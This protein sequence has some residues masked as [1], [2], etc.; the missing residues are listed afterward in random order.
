MSLPYSAIVPITGVVESPTFTV[1]KKHMLLAVTS[2]LM[3]TST[4]YLEFSGASAIADFG[5]YFGKSMA[6]YAQLQK[7]FGFISKNGNAPEKAV[8]ARW[9]NTDTAAFIKGK[10][11]SANV[12]TLNA[13]EDGALA[14]TMNGVTTAVTGIDFSGASAYSDI[15]SILQLAFGEKGIGVSVVYNS[16]TGGFIV[17]SSVTGKDSTTGGISDIDSS[18]SSEY[19]DIAGLLGLADAELSQGVNAESFAE[20]CDRIYHANTSGY[21]ITTLEKLTDSDIIPAVAW[22]QATLNGQSYNTMVRLVFNMNDKTEAKA[23]SSTLSADGYTGYV[24]CYDPNNEFINILDCAICASIDYQVDGGSINFNFQP[25]MGYTAI[26]TLGTVVDYQQG[27]TNASLVED[28][29]SNYIS[30]VYSVGFGSQEEIYYGYGLMAGDFGTESVQ[31]DESALE[32][33]IQISVLNGLSALNKVPLR[34][35]DA[36]DLVSSL[37][38]SPISQFVK[39]GVIAQG[40]V[41]T[42]TE[43]ASVAQMTGNANAAD[44][45]EMSG[46]YYKIYDLTEEDIA[47]K[48]VR[49]LLCYLAAGCLNQL[50]IVNKVYGA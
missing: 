13:I 5:S 12:S 2:P 6:E 18:E 8:V 1:E 14:I 22:L 19:T 41:L 42:A 48:R 38:A 44:S 47:A 15:A 37:L 10:K 26:T 28:L 24:I 17:T 23:L 7:Y 46:Y 43:K 9:Y 45:L 39:N 50:R 30:Y 35:Q 27:L 49:V 29:N 25:A 16:T 40:G 21:S 4:P 20:F 36:T 34:G 11:V 33:A 31:V 32:T 3:P